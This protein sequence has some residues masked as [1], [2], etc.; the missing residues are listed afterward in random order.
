[1]RRMRNGLARFLE[2]IAAPILFGV[3]VALALGGGAAASPVARP[4]PA[5]AFTLP[6]RTGTV[7]LDSLRG[8]V[9]LVDFW[10]SWCEPCRASFPW[11]SRLHERYA[12]RG[13]VIV[14]IDL[15]K[16]RPPA[17]QFLLDHPAAF[18]IAYD[19]AGRSAEAFKVKAMPTS[20]IVG[21]DGKILLAH[22]GF[23]PTKT[24]AIESLIAGAL[25]R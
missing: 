12:A 17:E 10:A 5:P 22:A 3:A 25:P 4:T 11:M 7:A 20:F 8:K 15:D 18:T 21:A 13:L 1:M 19:P 24:A 2:R 6:T 14:A 16:T 9:V 23:D